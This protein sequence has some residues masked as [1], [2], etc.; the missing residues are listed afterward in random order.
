MVSKPLRTAR[1]HSSDRTYCL[2][3]IGWDRPI[4]ACVCLMPSTINQPTNHTHT[5]TNPV[6]QRINQPTTL[7][8]TPLQVIVLGFKHHVEGAGE[9]QQYAQQ[10]ARLAHLTDASLALLG[11][12]FP[13]HIIGKPQQPLCQSHN[14]AEPS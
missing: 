6:Y 7:P 1:P 4:P 9:G 10:Y 8:H 14:L 11:L 13:R 12:I 3:P 5:Q 2:V